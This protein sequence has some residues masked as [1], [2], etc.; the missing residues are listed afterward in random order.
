MDLPSLG[1]LKALCDR[2]VFQKRSSDQI[3]YVKIFLKI[4]DDFFDVGLRYLTL[5]E[6]NHLI[7]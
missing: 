7:W 6:I 1:E 4:H 2:Q 5:K 3:L